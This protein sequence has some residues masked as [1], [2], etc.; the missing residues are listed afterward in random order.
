M[1]ATALASAL[2]TGEV[3]RREVY[4]AFRSCAGLGDKLNAWAELY[5]DIA[6]DAP[7]GPL[8]GVPVVRKDLG[9]PELG[10]LKEYGTPLAA[11]HRSA[12]S[13]VFF[14]RLVDAGSVVV[15]RSR[16]PELGLSVTC[17]SAHFGATVNPYRDGV[18]AGGS[19]GGSAAL[20][21]A[22]IVPVGHGDDG[23]GSLRIPAACCGL[24]GLKPSRGTISNSPWAGEDLLGL[25]QAFFVTRS[26]RDARLLMRVEAVP[27]PGDPFV[28][29]LAASQRPGWSSH[30]GKVGL[31]TTRW[32]DL[33]PDAEHVEAVEA[34]G[35]QL[36]H[37]G[38]VVE[39]IELAF[40]FDR[41][42]EVIFWV[43]AEAACA[44]AESISAAT[45][46]PL[47]A[48]LLQPNTL[49]WIDAGR[50]RPAWQVYET[51]D[52]INEISR[53]LGASFA[54]YDFVITPTVADRPP[55]TGAFMNS[56]GELAGLVELNRAMENYV[57]YCGPFNITGQPAISVPYGLHSDGLPKALQIVG[58]TGCDL[59][60][61]DIAEVVL[62]PCGWPARSVNAD[63]SLS[64]QRSGA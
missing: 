62:R 57:Q 60:I 37:L 47:S 22:G 39:Y 36:E 27:A 20:V 43:F 7:L 58:R 53:Y 12:T 16:V 46:R 48:E 13:S 10:R 44:L 3:S 24:V 2:A 32:G 56:V 54:A 18:S 4:E 38:F 21:S 15:G 17:E 63:A 1:D 35:R 59:D 11:G 29:G 42:C 41:Y 26:V 28:P 30:Q 14:D 40:P 49:K 51:F 5:D 23:G 34:A 50:I 31:V 61:L 55:P 6:I 33:E 8:T 52:H 64:A 19:S 45:G 9:N 25:D